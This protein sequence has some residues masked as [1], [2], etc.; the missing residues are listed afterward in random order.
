MNLR[1]IRISFEWPNH[2]EEII[3][4]PADD[5]H[6]F[7]INLRYTWNRDL[8]VKWPYYIF[9]LLKETAPAGLILS[10]NNSYTEQKNYWFFFSSLLGRFAATSFHSHLLQAFG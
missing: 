1:S 9:N 5:R 2:L 4:E 8:E 7:V 3:P 10:N 6:S